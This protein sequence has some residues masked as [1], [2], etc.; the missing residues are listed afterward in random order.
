MDDDRYFR[1]SN[2]IRDHVVKDIIEEVAEVFPQ[3]H[4]QYDFIEPEGKGAGIRV[5]GGVLGRSEKS[6]RCECTECKCSGES[7]E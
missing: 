7:E 4:Y 3:E 5:Y 6:D 2:M 1:L